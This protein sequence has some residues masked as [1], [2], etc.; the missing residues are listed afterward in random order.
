MKKKQIR[1]NKP[2]KSDVPV[3]HLD[4][5]QY[6]KDKGHREIALINKHNQIFYV[7][8]P[9]KYMTPDEIDKLAQDYDNSQLPP[10]KKRL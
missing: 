2:V 6:I 5:L 8:K 3:C 10:G 9:K 7:F 1:V 4:Y